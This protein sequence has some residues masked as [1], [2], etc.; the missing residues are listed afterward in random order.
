MAHCP[1]AW[2]NRGQSGRGLRGFLGL[3]SEAMPYSFASLRRVGEVSIVPSNKAFGWVAEWSKAA[4][5]KTAVGESPPGV[6]ISPH[7]LGDCPDFRSTKMG[8]A[9]SE[10]PDKRGGTSL[11][12]ERLAIRSLPTSQRRLWFLCVPG[13]WA[14]TAGRGYY[15]PLGKQP[16]NSING[17]G[18]LR[19]PNFPTAL[20]RRG[21]P[22]RK[23]RRHDTPLKQAKEQP[24]VCCAL[25]QIDQQQHG[26]CV[27]SECKTLYAACRRRRQA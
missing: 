4:V 23:E 12:S 20:A 24:R 21:W 16:R 15:S 3:L 27:S 18:I 22:C 14:V 1:L 6:Q 11:S 5:L 19:S 25:G 17:G 7:P 8:L 26:G 13:R 9:P 2:G 10:V